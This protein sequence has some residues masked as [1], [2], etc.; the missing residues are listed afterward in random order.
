[1]YNTR[2][3]RFY[4]PL[5]LLGAVILVGTVGYALMEHWSILD[6]F[7]MTL[8]TISTV[9]FGEVHALD[10]VGKVFTILIIV[11]GISVLTLFIE[12]LGRMVVAGEFRKILW[13]QRVEKNIQD[14][15]GHILLC[16]YGKVGHE[17]HRELTQAR[18]PVVIVE[19]EEPVARELEKEGLTFLQGDAT[20]E[21]TLT[22]A[23]IRRARGL[24][25]ALD[26]DA[27][28]VYVC[29]TARSLCP[30]LLIVA[31]AADERA[32]KNLKQA[33]AT[34]V[35]S[36]SVIGGMQMAQAIIRP[37]VVDFIHLATQSGK[38][39]LQ[40]EEIRLRTPSDLLGKTLRDSPLRSKYKVI[41][42]A[43][44]KAAG[45]TIYNPEPDALLEEGDTLIVLGPT[46]SMAALTGIRG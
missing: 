7:Y 27:D 32:I 11:G 14:M 25:T 5:A 41:V 31:R 20:T 13:R 12:T 4:I 44:L 33:G 1:M 16:G 26:N 15:E 18:I 46:S 3:K 45:T 35:T 28:N 29:L 43:I 23:G 22:K 42:V 2:V 24:V 36:P 38:L 17:V 34:R 6:A 39:D 8:L 40:L 21:E 19:K 30:N 37:A 9:G 10:S